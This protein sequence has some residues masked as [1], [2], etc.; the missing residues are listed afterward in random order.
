MPTSPWANITPILEIIMDLS[1]LPARVLDVGAGYGKF[2]LLCREYLGF[3][4]S[5]DK[6]RSVV[7]DGIE[8]FP[9]YLGSLQ[10]SIYDNLHVGDARE[11]LPQFPTDAYDLVLLIDVVEHFSRAD[12]LQILSECRRVGKVFIVSTP[13]LYWSQEN[14]WGNPYER[15]Q[16]LWSGSDFRRMGATRVTCAENWLAVFAKAPYAE[17]MALA[18]RMWHLGQKLWPARLRLRRRHSIDA[19]LRAN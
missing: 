17:R 10:R 11:L 2:G 5:P 3:W 7:V 19:S 18:Y 1:P 16:S 14:A 9:A 13:R 12:G 4:N 6:Q 8:A 15:H